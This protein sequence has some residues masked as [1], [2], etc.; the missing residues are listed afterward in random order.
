[1]NLAFAKRMLCTTIG[2]RVSMQ[3]KC[4]L[5]H[6]HHD[7]VKV[8]LNSTENL[9]LILSQPGMDLRGALGAINPLGLEEIAYKFHLIL[10]NFCYISLV[11]PPELLSCRPLLTN[12]LDP[13][14]IWVHIL[15]E[16]SW[17]NLRQRGSQLQELPLRHGSL[18]LDPASETCS[19]IIIISPCFT[20]EKQIDEAK[21]GAGH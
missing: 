10:S 20:T 1:M 7:S 13:C 4:P 11:S 18:P 15:T 2:K 8:T 19:R 12:F 16:K 14:L 6:N 17:T 5:I 21:L 9:Q 3:K